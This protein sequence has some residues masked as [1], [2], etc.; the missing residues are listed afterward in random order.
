MY[1]CF[2]LTDAPQITIKL[3][4][5]HS[6]DI[7]CS[8]LSGYHDSIVPFL[9]ADYPLRAEGESENWCD[10]EKE[11]MPA[12]TDE[13]W[14]RHCECG[15]EFTDSD[16]WQLFTERLMQRSDGGPLTTMRDAPAGAMWFAWWMKHRNESGLYGCDWD[17]QTTPELIVRTP[18][19]SWNID[20]RASNCTMPQDRTHR[21]W[22]RHGEPPNIHVDKSGHTCNAG[23]GSIVCGKYHGFLHN[24]QLT[25]NL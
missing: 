3:R 13:R 10:F 17:N 22:V 5:Y 16:N 20:S 11:V 2:L 7:K 15:Y 1:P 18:G 9:V 12:R 4:R 6:S 25:A 14:P 19:G 24:G 21:C 8:G 23:A